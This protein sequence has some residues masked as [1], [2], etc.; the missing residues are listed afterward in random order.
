M[1][2]LHPGETLP[3][4]LDDASLPAF[5]PLREELEV[6]TCVVGGGIAGLTTAYLLAREGQRV[7][8]LESFELASGQ[9]GRTTAHFVTALDDRYFELEKL[10][11]E[12]GARLAAESHAAAL[13]RVERIVRD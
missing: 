4:W 11:G 12:E 2:A 3:F 10:H 5:E 13:D 9:T 8:V 7:C 1:K 6:D